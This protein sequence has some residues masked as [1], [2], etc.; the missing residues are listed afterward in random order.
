MSE[1]KNNEVFEI[2]KELV[3]KDFDSLFSV[4]E[5]QTSIIFSFRGWAISILTAY[6]GFLLVAGRV[7]PLNVLYAIP[8]FIIV[9]FLILEVAERGI[10]IKLLKEVRSLEKIF[11]EKDLKILKKKILKYEFRDLR[12]QKES[13]KEKIKYFW[14]ALY[15]P[16]V[17]FWYPF[18]IISTTIVI[19][20]IL[21]T[22]DTSTIEIT[23]TNFK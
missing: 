14:R 22:I 21:T 23:W 13:K 16:Q 20:L 3:L 9:S 4:Y 7:I 15:T 5:R 10:M 1:T 12:D 6:F 2:K 18:L 17:L 8:F 19:Q 11:M